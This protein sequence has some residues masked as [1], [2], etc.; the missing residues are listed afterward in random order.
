MIY[1]KRGLDF[2]WLVIKT[3]DKKD[4]YVNAMTEAAEAFKGKYS[5]V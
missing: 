4:E 2:V 5:F 1:H 3:D